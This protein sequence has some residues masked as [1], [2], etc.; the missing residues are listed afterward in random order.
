MKKPALLFAG[1]ATVAAVA[2]LLVAGVVSSPFKVKEAAPAATPAAA[3]TP[4]VIALANDWRWNLPA[5][6]PEPWVP[7]ENPMSEAKFQLGRHLF[8]DKRLSGNGTFACASCHFQHLAFTDGKAV[9]PGSTKELTLRSAQSIANAAYHPTITWANISLNTLERQVP[10]PLLGDNPIEMGVTQENIKEVMARISTDVDYQQRFKQAFP[11]H[12][13]PVSMD[14]IIN[15][16]ATFE[17]GVLSFNAKYDQVARQTASYTEAEARGHKLFFSGQA[18]CSQC[19][20]GFNFTEMTMQAKPAVWN[21]VYRNTGLYNLDGKGAYTNNNQ[22]LIG[23]SGK[24]ED[25]GKFRVA[26]L[27]NIEVTAPFMHDGSIATLE[28]VLAFYA[29][30]G[31]NITSGPNKGDGRKNPFKDDLLNKIRLTKA[32]QAD[33][34]VFLKTL[35]DHEFLSNPR[36]ADPFKQQ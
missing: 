33:I 35:T 25:M 32:E 28:Q 7:S 18:Q 31:R 12:Q 15:A 16:I 29:A 13:N 36:F 6:I 14:N 1:L 21:P 24:P 22:G 19:H 27:R 10:V 30:G 8:Y 11:D 26:S 3:S 4:V 20:S 23:V 34:I 17:R 5:D 9:S 2:G